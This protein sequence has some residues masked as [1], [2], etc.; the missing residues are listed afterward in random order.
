MYDICFSSVNLSHVI[1][2]IRSVKELRR[3]E[4]QFS[5]PVWPQSYLKKKNPFKYVASFQLR[6][7]Q[8]CLAVWTTAGIQETSPKRGQKLLPSADPESLPKTA[9]RKKGLDNSPERWQQSVGPQPQTELQLRPYFGHILG[10][11]TWCLSCLVLRTQNETRRQYLSWERKEDNQCLSCQSEFG[12]TRH[13]GLPP[14]RADFGDNSY[15]LS[16]SASF[17]R[18]LSVGPGMSRVS[19][20]VPCWSPDTVEEVKLLFLCLL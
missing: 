18:M 20:G 16:A 11:P 14:A 15:P 7:Q 1:L 2:I 8:I 5:T 10:V 6:Q 12:S 9:K 13:H 19:Q 4:K 3:E 17:P